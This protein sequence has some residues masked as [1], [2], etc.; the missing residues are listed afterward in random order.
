VSAMRDLPIRDAER[1][2]SETEAPARYL[3]IVAR[4]RPDILA[5]VRERLRD[6]VRIDVIADRRQRERRKS[7]DRWTP[8]RRHAERRRPTRHWDDLSVY[9]TLV[10]QKRVESYAELQ[11]RM[12]AVGLESRALREDNARL[13]AE[14]ARLGA[15]NARL[16]EA[17]AS[18]ERRVEALV[19]ADASLK[20]EI[21]AVLTQ[22]EEAV[23]EMIARF[24]AR[25]SPPPSTS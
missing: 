19:A 12:G 5:R 23:G 4:N 25:L 22:A 11:R 24:R 1:E 16:R 6:D 10:V 15:E 18:L 2:A 17:N 3:F 20:A 14:N 7:A 9:P 8:E 21:C 13:G